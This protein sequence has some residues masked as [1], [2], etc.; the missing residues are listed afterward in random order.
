MPAVFEELNG[1]FTPSNAE[2][3]PRL[4][5]KIFNL[6]DEKEVDAFCRDYSKEIPV[7][8]SAKTVT[9]DPMARLAVGTSRIGGSEAIS[10]GAYAFA[11]ANV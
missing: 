5:Q 6:D 8:G 11:L 7:P 2:K 1:H 9:Y 10:L 3:L 4:V